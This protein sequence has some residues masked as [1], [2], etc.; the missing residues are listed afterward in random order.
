VYIYTNYKLTCSR[1]ESSDT[2]EAVIWFNNRSIQNERNSTNIDLL[3]PDNPNES[4]EEELVEDEYEE[5]S[6]TEPES[7]EIDNTEVD[8]ENE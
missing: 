4:G 7:D 8:S 6:E 1:E 2:K 3:D 5:L